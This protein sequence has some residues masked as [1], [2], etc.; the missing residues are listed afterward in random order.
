ML[1]FHTQARGDTYA[2]KS[3][4]R[5]LDTIDIIDGDAMRTNAAVFAF[6]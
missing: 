3:L 6:S 5:F 2:Y 4:L 1:I